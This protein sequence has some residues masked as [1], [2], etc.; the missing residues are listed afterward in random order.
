MKQK[1]ARFSFGFSAFRL[2]LFC[3]LPFCL[4][5]GLDTAC[6]VLETRNSV[7]NDIGH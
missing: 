1:G 3:L 5:S 2:L 4:L 6:G 7:L